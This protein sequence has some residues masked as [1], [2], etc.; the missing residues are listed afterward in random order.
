MCES[1]PNVR[2]LHQNQPVQALTVATG[3][4]ASLSLEC[5]L[6]DLPGQAAFDLPSTVTASAD[7]VATDLHAATLTIHGSHAGTSTIA[8]TS[9]DGATHYGS[10]AVTVADV[11]HLTFRSTYDVIPANVDVAFAKE[12]GTLAEVE[13]ASSTNIVLADDDMIVTPPMGATPTGIRPGVFD[14]AGTPLGDQTIEVASAGAMHSAPFVVVDHADAVALLDA[15]PTIPASGDTA[16]LCFAATT[17]G[18]FVAGLRWAYD[19]EGAMQGGA[20]CQPVAK[21]EDADHD[22]R[23][24]ITATAGGVSTQVE[25][26]IQ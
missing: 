25:A 7:A 12:F 19:I 15:H 11:D 24:A 3:G 16:D 4:T 5:L 1:N 21:A 26:P 22:G 6:E 9:G 2:F 10:L 8:I 23:V 20:N 18:R 13:L 17:N 14:I